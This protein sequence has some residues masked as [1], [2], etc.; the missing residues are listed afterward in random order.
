MLGILLLRSCLCIYQDLNPP[1]CPWKDSRKSKCHCRLEL[2]YPR[3]AFGGI[4]KTKLCRYQ[5]ISSL[6][7]ILPPP[8]SLKIRSHKCICQ[9]HPSKNFSTY[10]S[11]YSSLS[12]PGIF[13]GST[14][15]LSLMGILPDGRIG[16]AAPSLTAQR[17]HRVDL[18]RPPSRDVTSK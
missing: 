5:W 4:F 6:A 14:R 7:V 8:G 15:A 10:F 3:I 17:N 16:L 1:N 13:A 18:R 11:S 2:N 12:F 9:T